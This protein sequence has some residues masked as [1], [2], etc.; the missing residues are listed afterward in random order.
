M[1]GL[2]NPASSLRVG[3]PANLVAVDGKGGLLASFVNG[4]KA[5]PLR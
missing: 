5:S 4:K 3:Q 1:A 2:G